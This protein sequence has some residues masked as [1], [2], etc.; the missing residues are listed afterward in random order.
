MTTGGVFLLNAPMIGSVGPQSQHHQLDACQWCGRTPR[1]LASL[2]LIVHRGD[3]HP[4]ARITQHLLLSRELVERMRDGGLD[5]PCSPVQQELVD[6]VD[7][8]LIDLMLVTMRSSVPDRAM[9]FCPTC[10]ATQSSATSEINLLTARSSRGGA[11]IAELDLPDDPVFWVGDERIAVRESVAE[12]VADL[13]DVTLEPV[14]LVANDGTRRMTQLRRAADVVMPPVAAP[15]PAAAPA[16]APAPA[17]KAPAATP[18][19]SGRMSPLAPVSGISL[20]SIPGAPPATPPPSGRMPALAPMLDADHDEDV[21]D[22][23]VLESEVLRTMEP[24]RKPAPDIAPVPRG[25][26]WGDRPR[27]LTDSTDSADPA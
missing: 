17:P 19:T 7:G 9:P 5:I 22:L 3:G 6:G 10:L 13:P 18:P 15:T 25:G 4:V 11:Q 14:E 16:P 21:D 26:T 23:E 1:R 24:P 8:Q 27:P 2:H 20:P 12:W